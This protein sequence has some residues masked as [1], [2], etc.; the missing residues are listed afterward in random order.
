MCE[1]MSESVQLPSAAL[2]YVDS[3]FKM[4]VSLPVCASHAVLLIIV[5]ACLIST[6]VVYDEMTERA[7]LCRSPV[8]P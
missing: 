8:S 5:A 1:C 6:L 7:R 4:C 2:R 3:C